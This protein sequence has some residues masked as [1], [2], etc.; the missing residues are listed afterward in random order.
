MPCSNILISKIWYSLLL[1]VTWN[2]LQWMSVWK[3]IITSVNV[4]FCGVGVWKIWGPTHFVLDKAISKHV[5]AFI[6]SEHLSPHGNQGSFICMCRE[7]AAQESS[8][9]PLDVNVLLHCW[10]CSCLNSW[11]LGDPQ[12]VL[13]ESLETL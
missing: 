11:C 3:T 6:V 4:Y 10:G 12:A 2:G 9:L 8:P 5:S 13:W 7:I 1:H